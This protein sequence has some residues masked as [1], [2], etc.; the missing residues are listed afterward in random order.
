[1]VLAVLGLSSLIVLPTLE[2]S[3]REREAKRSALE[4]A[5]VARNLRGRALEQ[6]IP[7][8]LTLD[9]RH[10]SYRV[11]RDEEIRLPEKVSFATVEG[12]QTLEGDIRQFS[13]FPNGSTLP[14]EIG[15][16]IGSGSIP[17]YVHLEP[18]TGRIQV[19]RG[20]K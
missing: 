13:F 19:I 4:L 7:Q 5:A 18:L 16:S 15:V 9:L 17:Y 14:G 1:M 2:R 11:S 10:N 3:L 20:N 6:G 12:G 8:Q